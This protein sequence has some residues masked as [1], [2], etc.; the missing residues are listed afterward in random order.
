MF[1][2][3]RISIVGI[4]LTILFS[5]TLIS[6]YAEL[7]EGAAE[8]EDEGVVVETLQNTDGPKSIFDLQS[9]SAALIDASSGQ[10]LFEK[11]SHEKL[12]PAS[13]TKVMSLVLIMEAIDLGKVKLEDK[14]TC[15]E[16]AAGM[17]GSQIWLEPGEQMT[18]EELLKCIIVASAN[19]CTVMLAEH[20]Y[21][22]IEG[23]VKAMNEKAKELG[24]KDT[25]FVNATGLDDDN[26]YTTAYDIAL[27]SRELINKHTLVF[28]YT[29]IWMD[30]VRN[31]EFGLANTNKLIRYYKGYD[32]LKTGSTS[33][34]L[35]CLS[36]TAK[37]DNLRLIATVMAAPTS[38]IRN[39][40]VSKAI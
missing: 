32:G 25:N 4:V 26:H 13:V 27:M 5:F 22:S 16:Y 11:N 3:I 6:S 9:K 31:G 17:G 7:N 21:G 10:V 36:A 28:K 12:K 40:E 1:G 23:F 29:T 15:S 8:F 38:K 33:K 14:V 24:M 34:A 35:F 20:T 2:R 39:A 37:R 19:D 30:T 18:V